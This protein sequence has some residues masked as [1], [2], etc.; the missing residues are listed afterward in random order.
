MY[1]TLFL[2]RGLCLI[3]LMLFSSISQIFQVCI[4][5]PILV[6]SCLTVH[7]EHLD[8]VRERV[9][10]LDEN[11]NKSSGKDFVATSVH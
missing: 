2:P 6:I 10:L 5:F 7:I 9:L 11:T 1:S 8:Q 4:V 3:S